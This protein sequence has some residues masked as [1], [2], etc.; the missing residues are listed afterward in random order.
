VKK[1]LFSFLCFFS[2]SV[3]FGQQT[4]LLIGTIKDRQ[5]QEVLIGAA[6]QIDGTTQG[7]VTDATGAFRIGNIPVGSY[8]V[9]VSYL[10]YAPQTR[11]NIV[12]SSGN[13]ITLNIEMEPNGQSLGEV[14]V[15]ENRS[16]RV[17][18]S[19]TPLSVQNLSAEEIKSN[20]GGNFDISKVIQALPGVGG[21]AGSV[22]SFRNDI[23]IRGGG[24]NEN[25]YYLD[26]VEV[27]F[28]N[29]FS[30]QGSAGGPAGILNVSFIE[31]AT[32]FT[33][34]FPARYDNPL[35]SVLTFRQRD[36][37]PERVQ[38]NFR[39]SGT[40]A[41][42]TVEGP[43]SPKTTFLASARRSYLQLLFEL[44]DL[45]IRPDYWDF[46]Y[47]VTHKFNP[48]QS[49]T[50]L[51][52]GAIDKFTF[53]EPSDATPETVYL[54]SASP[55][56][57]QWTYTQGFSF[58][59]LVDNGYW[60]VTL[61][62][63][64]L[65]NQLDQFRDNFDGQQNDESK[66]ILGVKSQEIENKLRFDMNRF[67][68]DW[69]WSY[70]AGAQLV[71]YT[72]NSFTI[73][74]PEVKDSLG[75]VLQPGITEQFDTDIN[76]VKYGLFGQ[77]SRD[78]L[79]DRLTLSF[80]LR[81]D[82]NTYTNEG[83]NLLQ[84][85]SPRLS[86]SYGLTSQ[87]RINASV[88]RYYKIPIYTALG[89]KDE[90]GD[91]VNKSLPYARADHYVAGLEYIPRPTL[92]FTL[93]GFYKDYADYPVSA[94]DGISLANQGG[95]FGI[96]GNERLLGVG[97]GE[98]YG[99]ELFAQQK[100]NRNLFFTASYTL[101]WSKF[102]GLDGNLASSAW[103]NRHLV[104]LLLGRKFRGNWEMG[105][106]WRFQGGAPYTPFDEQASRY[107]YATTGRGTLDYDQ[108]NE[109]LLAPF[110]QFD[111]RLDKKW[112]FR[113]TTF[114]LYIDVQNAF[115][116][117]NPAYPEYSFKRKEDNSDWQTTDGQTLKSD[118]SNA[119]PVIFENDEPAVVPTIGFIFEF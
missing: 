43:L 11:Y 70:G 3:A 47:K 85:L 15:T 23:V 94:R 33:S 95:N 30:T 76:F 48:K 86:A 114:D 64:V 38:G 2:A 87:L 96:I 44:L 88:G 28:I 10:G 29:H 110:S 111:F 98:A 34:A 35:S 58:R 65:D 6:V 12:V 93:E 84:T 119:I 105:L 24:P 26:G 54:L 57:N 20:P 9:T 97:R 92:R 66:R 50:V 99:V 103:D 113:K 67:E 69:R 115:V 74:Q 118:G 100:L 7:A 45:A 25:V 81:A 104:S 83:G 117:S 55:K 40:E 49:L 60:N 16:I 106:K 52:V 27:P 101:F 56:I 78:M 37:S 41:A 112:N 107:N 18:S 75:N 80:G 61:S 59:Q 68:G 42:L 22:G 89:F 39:L 71:R 91:L 109:Q 82:G 116:Q 8:N 53:A 21:T 5:S 77:V 79:A 108:L 13:A 31:D 102:G 4:G 51:G 36:G 46:Q 62:R 90:N 19:E 17:A 72:N 14:V 32:L 1:Q 73:L 63:N